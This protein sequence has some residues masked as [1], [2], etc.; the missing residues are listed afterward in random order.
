MLLALRIDGG[1]VCIGRFAPRLGCGWT[2]SDSILL[3]T[4]DGIFGVIIA[5][6]TIQFQREIKRVTF[7]L[8]VQKLHLYHVT[9]FDDVSAGSR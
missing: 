1:L 5:T 6:L 2:D 4:Y 7:I 3:F 9:F 8:R